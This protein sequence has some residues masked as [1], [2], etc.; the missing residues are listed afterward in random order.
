MGRVIPEERRH[1]HL[2]ALAGAA[3]RGLDPVGV[4]EVYDAERG[5]VAVMVVDSKDRRW[6]VEEPVSAADAALE[7]LTAPLLP[8]LPSRLPF[9]VPRPEG[10][11]VVKKLG[12]ITVLPWIED[13]RIAFDDVPPGPGLAA[14]IGRTLAAIHN[15]DPALYE[16]A[17]VPAYDAEAYR[18]RRLAELDRAAATG[19]IP[20]GLLARWEEALELVPLWRFA[21]TPVHGAFD[22]D[23]VRVRFAD[24]D[25]TSGTVTA[26]TSWH[27]TR[28]ADP[29]DDFAALYDEAHPATF[30]TVLEAYSQARHERPDRGLETRARLA[31][32]LESVSALLRALHANDEVVVQEIAGQ[33]RVLDAETAEHPLVKRRQPTAPAPAPVLQEQAAPAAQVQVEGA[34]DIAA[35]GPAVEAAGHPEPTSAAPEQAADAA[36]ADAPSTVGRDDAPDESAAD[37]VEP[38]AV[39]FVPAGSSDHP[40]ARAEAGSAL[41]ALEQPVAPVVP[42]EHLA[43]ADEV[44]GSDIVDNAD[45][46]A[47]VDVTTDPA[48]PAE[49]VTV[50]AV[51]TEAQDGAQNDTEPARTGSADQAAPAADD[52]EPEFLDDST[53]PVPVP[54]AD[55]PAANPSGATP[56]RLM[57]PRPDDTIEIPETYRR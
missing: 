10:S 47:Q 27:A 53:V 21:A 23:A 37:I 56:S 2:A 7:D 31:A 33:L 9:D 25:S 45:N 1:L 19:H 39:T 55:A 11:V 35:T 18:R 8:L 46:A 22:G 43:E 3:V 13:S 15:L 57:P 41:D 20:T 12:R 52:D 51:G 38:R 40:L 36:P 49:G 29:A 16:E 48:D 26:V 24:D 50:D 34:D 44:D 30:D 17:G 14:E 6:L 54:P 4:A 42:V 28:V 32:E 5:H